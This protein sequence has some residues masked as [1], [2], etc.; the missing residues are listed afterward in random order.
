M[1]KWTRFFALTLLLFFNWQLEAQ[2]QVD[3]GGKFQDLLESSETYDVY[4]VIPKDR[5]DAF[6]NEVADSLSSKGASLQSLDRELSLAVE[7]NRLKEENIRQ[8]N[9]D[10]VGLQNNVQNISFVGLEIPKGTYH[11]IVWLIILLLLVAGLW[12]GYMYR[13]SFALTDRA[14]KDLHELQRE[15]DSFRD[16][17]REKEVKLKRELQTALNDIEDLKRV[18]R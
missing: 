15:Y 3:L 6:W 2:D 4:K 13:S 17:S 18:K 12:V 10:L 5:L 9:T 14:R 11:L 7:E 1:D 8:L 16:R